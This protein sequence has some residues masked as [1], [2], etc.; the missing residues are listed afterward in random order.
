MNPEATLQKQIERYHQLTGE[1]RLEIA[2]RMHAEWLEAART[3][4]LTQFPEAAPSEIEEELRNRQ[5]L[6]YR[7]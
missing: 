3:K 4:Y 6:A 7:S 1:Q 2:L 5:R